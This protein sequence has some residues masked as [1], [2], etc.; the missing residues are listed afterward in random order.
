MNS[1]A[2]LRNYTTEVCSITDC[3]ALFAYLSH[4][5]SEPGAGEQRAN[6]ELFKLQ[7]PP[8]GQPI[9]QGASWR[10]VLVCH[11]SRFLHS[12]INS[13]VANGGQAWQLI[14]SV[15]RLVH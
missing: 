14:E 4:I 10:S 1:N 7:H 5:I 9:T 15:V 11:L 6:T 2:S 13:W 3:V 12:V 8:H